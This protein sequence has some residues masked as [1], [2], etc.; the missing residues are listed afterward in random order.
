MSEDEKA[1]RKMLAAALGALGLSVGLC[2]DG[3]LLM[4]LAQAASS[5]LQVSEQKI[6]S[7]DWKRQS[8]KEFKLKEMKSKE[9]KLNRQ[10]SKEAKGKLEGIDT[11]A[12][13]P[14]NP[15]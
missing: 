3:A 2:L 6:K 10:R 9:V 11:K 7:K 12:P 13:T 4:Q 14:L 5:N 15:K 8:S 1:K